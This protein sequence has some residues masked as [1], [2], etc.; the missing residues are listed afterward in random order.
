MSH[1]DIALLDFSVSPVGNPGTGDASEF[2][3]R[4]EGDRCAAAHCGFF[5]WRGSLRTEMLMPA[6]KDTAADAG[7]YVVQRVGYDTAP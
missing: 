2:N 1:A 7:Q 3:W 4:R 5:R 6:Q